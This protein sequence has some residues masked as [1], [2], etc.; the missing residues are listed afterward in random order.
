MITA[1]NSLVNNINSQTSVISGLASIGQGY[2]ITSKNSTSLTDSKIDASLINQIGNN[3][4]VAYA[5]S[6]EMI[7]GTLATENGSYSVNILGVNNLQAY[8]DNNGASINGAISQN[9]TDV[10]VGVILANLASIGVNDSVSVTVDNNTCQLIVA[11][12]TQTT[13][14]S[15]SELIMPLNS[16]N[17]HRKPA[18][19][20]FY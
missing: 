12:I 19:S 7:Q 17:Y 20:L 8:L 6:E 2:L 15:D 4:N 1:T 9:Q 14:Q 3:S 11:G 18:N 5:T 13:K 16:S 10:D